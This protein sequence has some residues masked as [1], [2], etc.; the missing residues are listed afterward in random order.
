MKNIY[1]PIV[2]LFCLS[3][4]YKKVFAR[5]ADSD[6]ENILRKEKVKD[7]D[8]LKKQFEELKGLI[9]NK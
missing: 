4:I 1:K 3:A 5:L 7:I 6:T 9:Q 2:L 8:E